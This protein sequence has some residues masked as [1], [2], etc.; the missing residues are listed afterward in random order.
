MLLLYWLRN[1]VLKLWYN[2]IILI[3]TF[4]LCSF[5]FNLWTF[6]FW[7][8]H[9]YTTTYLV[10]QA[11]SRHGPALN[12]VLVVVH[13]SN[14]LGGVGGR[15][16]CQNMWFPPPPPP[17]LNSLALCLPYWSNFCVSPIFLY[18]CLKVIPGDYMQ[19]IPSAC[20]PKKICCKV[21]NKFR[22][23]LD[24][25]RWICSFYHSNLSV[26]WFFSFYWCSLQ[27]SSL[28]HFSIK[29]ETNALSQRFDHYYSWSEELGFSCECDQNIKM[30]KKN[31]QAKHKK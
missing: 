7:I 12:F 1:L 19:E 17:V 6:S 18:L 3:N 21:V 16:I 10:G 9:L 4:S 14:E 22:Q 20:L 2:C 30:V 5:P 27:L 28:F 25:N 13:K 8:L 29:K 23:K 15:E 24:W 26:Q 31:K 11:F